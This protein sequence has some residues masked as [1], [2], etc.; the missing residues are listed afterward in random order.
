VLRFSNE[1]SVQENDMNL[2]NRFRFFHAFCLLVASVG[3]GVPSLCRAA[4]PSISNVRVSQPEHSREL[5]VDYDLVCGNESNVVVSLNVSTNNGSSWVEPLV[6]N[7][8]GD[9]G[10]LAFS[11]ETR[12]TIF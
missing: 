9:V 5:R 8:R 11:S 3:V 4:T 6:Q 12:R 7:L 2:T 10:V 1:L